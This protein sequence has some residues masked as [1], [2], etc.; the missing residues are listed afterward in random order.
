[1][2][3]DWDLILNGTRGYW[4]CEEDEHLTDK[5]FLST[6]D[7]L[8]M[9]KGQYKPYWMSDEDKAKI[10]PLALAKGAAAGK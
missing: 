2:G 1:M 9:R 6:Y 3:Y 4:M 8:R 7:L 10:V 5:K